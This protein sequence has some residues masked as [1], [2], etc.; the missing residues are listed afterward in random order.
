MLFP[1]THELVGNLRDAKGYMA[2]KIKFI[3]IEKMLRVFKKPFLKSL[4]TFLIFEIFRA[5]NLL[6]TTLFIDLIKTTSQAG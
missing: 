4:V 3:Q 5:Q 2:V 1:P 6:S